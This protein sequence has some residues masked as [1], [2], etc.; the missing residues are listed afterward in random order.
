MGYKETLDWLFHQLPMYQKIGGKAYKKDL[1]NTLLLMR[2]LGS[3]ERKIKAIHVAGTNGKGS[4]CHMLASILQE[5]GYRVGLYTSP[6]LIDFRERIKINGEVITEEYVV[7]FVKKHKN[8][9]E[10]NSLSFFE[11]TVGLAFDYFS[12]TEV[13]YV[14]LETG[15]GGRLD[16]TNV[17]DPLVSV[18]TNIG[19]DHVQFLGNKLPLIAAEK[20]GIIKRNRPVIIGEFN[21][22]TF[23]VF[24]EIAARENS[25]LHSAFNLKDEN[26]RCG[27][28]G[29]C[30]K[31]NI[32]TVL[33]TVK[34]LK[35]IGV[36]INEKSVED[37]FVNVIENT[38]LL[39]RYQT[40][41]E[42]P[43]IICDTGHNEEA[44]SLIVEQLLKEDYKKLHFVLGAVDDKDLN[45]VFPL[46]PKKAYYYCTKPSI[47]RGVSENSLY[48]QVIEFGLEGDV[49]TSVEIAVE[50]A[51]LNANK[52][53]LIF[54]GGST[55]IV[56]DFLIH[57]RKNNN[58]NKDKMCQ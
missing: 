56:S 20:A 28:K 26:Y 35:E 18:I 43:K 4:T 19:L 46:L 17:V 48:N 8:F 2:Y 32:K 49:F 14:V 13:D 7:D 41:Q 24:N 50:Q 12:D 30:Q 42:S 23:P 6:H 1:S 58:F 22:D 27:L 9:F 51:L 39:G 31:Y 36:Q 57:L 11:M 47:A 10:Q 45:K 40:L 25:S 3:P 55:F 34:V 53:D 21:E 16:S 37:G 29:L 54:V 52:S 15:L 38:S 44:I 33:Q 5:Q